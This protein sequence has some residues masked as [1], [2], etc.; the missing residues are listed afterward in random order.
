MKRML[1]NATQPEELRVA[2][3]DGQKLF[4]LDI[5]NRTRVQKKSNIYKGKITRVEPSL[6]AAFVDFGAERHGFLPLKEISREYFY[7]K[8]S[9]IEGRFTIKDV[10]KEG[11]EVIVQVDKEERG[12]K[13]AALTTFI[14]LAGRYMV[15]M[16][17]NPR[18]GGISRRVEGDER[19]ELK[20]VLDSVSAPKGMG[21][22]VRTAGVGRNEEELQ[23]DLDYLLAIWDA[24]K[25]A[26]D[27]DQAPFLIY[28]EGNVIV[29]AIRDYL[30]ADIGEIVIDSETAYQEAA[31]FVSQI[32]PHNES[33]LKLY[34]DSV[35]LFNRYQIE[36]QIKSAY[37]REVSLP[38]GGSIVIDPTEAMVAI[39]I[40]S[41]RATKGKNIEDTAVRTN[42]EAADEIARQLRLRDIGGLVVIDFIDMN[43][44]RN[45]RAVENRMRDAL[46]MDRA[47]VQVG[48]ISRFGLMEMSR[49]RLR[50]SLGETSS[51][52]CPRC[53]GQGHIL[54]IKSTSLTAL[55]VIEEEALKERSAEIRAIVPVEVATYLLNEKR[56]TI[57]EIEKRNRLHVL[58]VPNLNLETPHFEVQ[59]LRDDQASQQIMPSYEIE[60]DTSMLEHEAE[61][62]VQLATPEVPAVQ[63]VSVAPQEPAPQR[64]STATAAVDEQAAGEGFF[65]RMINSMFGAPPAAVAEPEPEEPQQAPKPRSRNRRNNNGNRNGQGRNNQ[66]RKDETRATDSEQGQD[67][68]RGQRRRSDEGKGKRRAETARDRNGD[69][70]RRSRNKERDEVHSEEPTANQQRPQKRPA[71]SKP[72]AASPKKRDRRRDNKV[73]PVAAVASEEATDTLSAESTA[74][75]VAIAATPAVSSEPVDSAEPN[76]SV[77]VQA[78]TPVVEESASSGES[79][80]PS[81]AQSQQVDP[82][83]TDASATVQQTEPEQSVIAAADNSHNDSGF[84]AAEAIDYSAFGR[85]AND[86]RDNPKAPSEF[87]IRTRHIEQID[88]Q[89]PALEIDTPTIEEI[90]AM[91][92]PNDPRKAQ[93]FSEPV[94]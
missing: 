41:A 4:D 66:R 38:S 93:A 86:P 21:I 59:R 7:R 40:N 15:L 31:Q 5:E 60:T 22:I 65:K 30:R 46:E 54:D 14:S 17:N 36:S 78:E 84:K 89:A 50:P 90:Q 16:P 48:R 2:M 71:D 9:E 26:A 23:W 52:V 91:R 63:R 25:Q 3:V 85:A 45:Q 18:A 70:R 56:K 29:R 49:Q 34:Q 13:G 8:P 58:V 47:R 82:A 11:I 53:Q 55:R 10:I 79:S 80:P 76:D 6:E 37:D 42:L 57:Q 61:Q 19:A 28:P 32:M 94:H 39:D 27:D 77:S 73:K 74:A 75:D 81:D 43:E 92:A 72:K 64:D 88:L 87:A 83:V 51:I 44:N 12:N 69:G 68:N 35:P 20:S 67:D 62:D 24:V 1:I 33:K